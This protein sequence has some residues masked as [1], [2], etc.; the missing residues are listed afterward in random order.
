[1]RFKRVYVEI[2]NRCN[3][4]CSFCPVS[5]RP[6]RTMTAEE[7]RRAAEAIRPYCDYLYLHVK[8][9][10]LIHPQLEEILE[11]CRQLNF[12]VNLTTN[13]VLIPMRQQLL[14][15]APAVRQT[16]LSLH[17]YTQ[18]TH[19]PLEE[20]LER[21]TNYARASAE[22]GRYTVFRVWNLDDKRETTRD[23]QKTLDFLERSFSVEPGGIREMAARY[24]S[25]TLDKGIF[26]SFEEEFVW[27]S[28]QNPFLGDQGTCYGARTMAAVLADGTVVP[29]CLDGEG[30][31]P[32]GN[33]FEQP[34]GEIVEGKRMTAMARDL[35]NRQVKEPLCQRCGYRLRFGGGNKNPHEGK[36]NLRNGGLKGASSQEKTNE[37]N[38]EL[39]EK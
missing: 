26:V 27:P 7:F 39:K 21:L 9:E 23:G 32:L 10:P 38:R 34:F 28:L 22:L 36:R 3:L 11:I 5:S 1:M 19:G 13:G 31:C 33:L 16:N 30:E 15:S 6:A 35:T 17:S 2:T 25:V 14:L 24:R 37:F 12:Q 8:G 18:A 29:C 4:H 20:W